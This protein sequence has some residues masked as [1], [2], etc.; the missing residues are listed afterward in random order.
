LVD[1]LET[2]KTQYNTQIGTDKEGDGLH[3][4]DRTVQIDDLTHIQK[5]LDLAKIYANHLDATPALKW[6]DGL[7][8]SCI[9]EMTEESWVLDANFLGFVG[10]KGTGEL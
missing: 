9:K 3:F 1:L 8:V 4:D 10:A 6:E 7:M 2:Y 5:A